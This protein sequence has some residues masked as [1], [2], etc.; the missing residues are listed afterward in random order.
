MRLRWSKRCHQHRSP[1]VNRLG[2]FT[3]EV[4]DL[5]IGDAQRVS[6]P[7]SVESPAAQI[8]TSGDF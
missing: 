2:S 7:Q 5:T 3:Q 8:P 6:P 4:V 1:A